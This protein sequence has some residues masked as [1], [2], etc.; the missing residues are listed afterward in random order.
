VDGRQK[1]SAGMSLSELAEELQRMGA[2]EALNLD[3]GG[4]ST[5]VVRGEVKN[6]P[7]DGK[8]RPVGDAILVFSVS[9]REELASMEEAVKDAPAWARKRLL[10]EARRGLRKIERGR[11]L[12]N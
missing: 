3:G 5:L 1:A 12:V 8:E 9:T 11:H 4:S 10:D 7:S 6:R 2:V